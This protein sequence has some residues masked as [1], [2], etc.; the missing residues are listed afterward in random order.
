MPSLSYDRAVALA[1]PIALAAVV[2]AARSGVAPGRLRPAAG[3]LVASTVL[4][5][6]RAAAVQARKRRA[7]ARASLPIAWDV[8]LREPLWSRTSD[9][10]AVLALAA[11]LGA[12][13]AL[14]GSTGVGAGISATIALLGL[15]MQRTIERWTPHAMIFTADGLHVILRPL[16]FVIPWRDITGVET[17]A[18]G[19]LADVSVLSVQRVAASALPANDR[20]RQRVG[21]ALH[22]GSGVTGRLL[23]DGA[24]AGLD[25][26]T[27]ARAIREAAALRTAARPN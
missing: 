24:V 2:L 18:N 25:G 19:D 12:A 14:A 9:T 17:S 10:A 3:F 21:Y 1:N 11:M 7:R 5:A 15:A 22:D 4:A 6:A 8:P 26:G 23:L 20:A 16:R 13:A 27:L